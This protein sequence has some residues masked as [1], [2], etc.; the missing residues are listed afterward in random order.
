M[1]NNKS[2]E[3][4]FCQPHRKISI[5]FHFLTRFMISESMRFLW[6]IARILTILIFYACTR[7]G[8]STRS[9]RS[10]R[11]GRSTWSMRL[12]WYGRSTRTSRRRFPSYVK[13]AGHPIGR[14][15]SKTHRAQNVFSQQ[16]GIRWT[17]GI[18]SLF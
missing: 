15:N 3:F 18:I 13:P 10:T 6:A 7:T 2:F 12:T 5:F 4:F 8:R 9:R 11:S 17:T 16:P 1:K 14:Y